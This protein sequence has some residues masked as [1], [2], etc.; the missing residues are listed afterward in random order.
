VGLAECRDGMGETDEAVR[1]V[2]AVLARKPNFPAALSYRGQLAFKNA[3][4][5]EAENWLRQAIRANPSD[6]RAR[7]TL[8]LCLA[9]SSLEDEAREQQ[10]QLKQLEQ[11]VTRFNELV[12]K[13]IPK[14]P[15]DPALHCELGLLLKRSGQREQAIHWLQSALELDSTYAPARQALAELSPQGKVEQPQPA[16]P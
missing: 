3:Q 7:Y 2:D 8:I 10:K 1:L 4:L 6:V 14:R 5:T 9:Q 11:D 12:I 13:E 15:M 16:S